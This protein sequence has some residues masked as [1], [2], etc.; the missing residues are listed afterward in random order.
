MNTIVL[1][2][3]NSTTTFSSVYDTIFDVYVKSIV[4][5]WDTY[6]MELKKERKEGNTYEKSFKCCS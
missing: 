2:F 1:Q 6:R 4:L 5:F 3:Y